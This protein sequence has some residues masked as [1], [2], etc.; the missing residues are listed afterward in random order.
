MTSIGIYYLVSDLLRDPGIFSEDYSYEDY[1]EEVLK[2]RG[3]S[4]SDLVRYI[5]DKE[6]G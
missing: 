3:A 2:G 5:I 6:G 4:Y 1:I